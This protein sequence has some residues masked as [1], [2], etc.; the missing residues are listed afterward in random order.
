MTQKWAGRFSSF[1]AFAVAV[2][3]VG[4]DRYFEWSNEVSWCVFLIALP[5]VYLG[6]YNI[7]KLESDE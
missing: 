6:C 4:C 5:I 3:F 2:I 7:R 1:Y